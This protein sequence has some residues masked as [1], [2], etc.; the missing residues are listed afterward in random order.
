MKIKKKDGGDSPFSL[1]IILTM[2][3]SH[4]QKEETD[5]KVKKKETK[6]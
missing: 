6:T 4:T 5:N 2:I 3:E 1:Q